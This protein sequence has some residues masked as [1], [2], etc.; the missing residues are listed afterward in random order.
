ML[1][2]A[3]TVTISPIATVAYVHII[4][5]TITAV[6]LVAVL[7]TAPWLFAVRTDPIST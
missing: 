6:T 2:G 4:P 5:T 1:T 3:I 7:T